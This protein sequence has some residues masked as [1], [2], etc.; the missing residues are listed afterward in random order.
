M[1]R[2]KFNKFVAWALIIF[3]ILMLVPTVLITM[4]S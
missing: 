4:F 2:N 3:M 1:K